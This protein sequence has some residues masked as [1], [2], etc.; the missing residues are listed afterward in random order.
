MWHEG[1]GA[2]DVGGVEFAA[3]ALGSVG[4]GQLGGAGAGDDGGIVGAVHGHGQHLGGAVCGG[5]SEGIGVVLASDKLVV[6]VVHDVGPG[7]IRGD[8]ELAVAV[9]AGHV[10]L[11][12]EGG[13]AVDVGGVEIAGGA[14]GCVGLS[15]AGGAGAGDD[16]GVVDTSKLDLGRGPAQG[17]VPE[18]DRVGE[19]VAQR[20]P[21]GERL[22]G[23]P[24]RG[25]QGAGIV[26]HLALRGD[27]DFGAKIA[28]VCADR[29]VSGRVLGKKICGGIELGGGR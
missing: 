22:Q 4:F 6:C 5:D 23:L 8:G 10:G 25:G 27:P 24:E 1:G 13:G 17:T 28:G 11:W 2:V 21:G 18:A 19:A 3:G 14:L 12:H 26:A 16:G 20:L 29:L 15:Q 7:A 9:A